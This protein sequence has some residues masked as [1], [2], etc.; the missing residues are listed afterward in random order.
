MAGKQENGRENSPDYYLEKA[1]VMRIQAE[2]AQSEEMRRSYMALAA[3]WARLADMARKA[4][5][6]GPH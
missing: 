1:S 2:N 5:D 4:R 3:D 6:G